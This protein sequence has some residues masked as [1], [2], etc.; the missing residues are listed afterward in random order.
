VFK[1]SGNFAEKPFEFAGT[2]IC[3][4]AMPSFDVVSEVSSMEVENAVNQA[5]K[6]P[7][8]RFDFKGGKPQIVLEKNVSPLGHARGQKIT[9]FSEF[10]G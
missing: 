2:H 6:E 3:N 7:A 5:R 4:F 1:G 9:A 8:N 10:P